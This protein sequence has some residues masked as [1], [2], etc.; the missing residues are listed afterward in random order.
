MDTPIQDLD[1]LKSEENAL[2]QSIALNKITMKLLHDRAA[3]CKRLLIALV[4][5]ILV[6][7][8]IVAAFL[9]Y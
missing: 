1:T 5:S 7:L 3:D 2:D 6:N 9:W 8:A 4:I